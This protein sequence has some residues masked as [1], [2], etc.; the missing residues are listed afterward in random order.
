MVVSNPLPFQSMHIINAIA[1]NNYVLVRMRIQARYYGYTV[2]CLC[3]DYSRYS[4]SR[5][6]EVQVR[7]SIG[8]LVMFS[9]I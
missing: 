2:V 4:C 5:I 8:L 9:W 3:V 1:Y 6:N 7:V